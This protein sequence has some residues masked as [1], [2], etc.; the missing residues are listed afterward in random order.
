M[1][2]WTGFCGGQ[3][4]S[5]KEQ[6]SFPDGGHRV[7]PCCLSRVCWATRSRTLFTRFSGGSQPLSHLPRIIKTQLTNPQQLCPSDKARL[8]GSTRARNHSAV[9]QSILG[10]GE[11]T[12]VVKGQSETPLPASLLLRV[13]EAADGF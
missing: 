9:V 2:P 1:E 8:C 5:R 4:T 10:K 12:M 11:P 13:A 3:C 7:P 6:S